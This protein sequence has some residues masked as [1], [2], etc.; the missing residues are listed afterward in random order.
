[1]PFPQLFFPLLN[2]VGEH[3]AYF[4]GKGAYRHFTEKFRGEN[5]R[6]VE[7]KNV[8]GRKLEREIKSGILLGYKKRPL[9]D[10]RQ[11]FLPQLNQARD[12]R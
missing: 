5:A 9:Q 7:N 2:N 6:S 4:K 11:I 10:Q 3:K 1:M 12:L 8:Y